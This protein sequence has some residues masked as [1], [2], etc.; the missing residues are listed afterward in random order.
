MA[1]ITDVRHQDRANG[2]VR[3]DL[4]FCRKEIPLNVVPCKYFSYPP[5]IIF[6][7]PSIIG[8]TFSSIG[9]V[10]RLDQIES[11]GDSWKST[12]KLSV[13]ID[14]VITELESILVKRGLTKIRELS[15]AGWVQ[16]RAKLDFDYVKARSDAEILVLDPPSKCDG[17]T[18]HMLIPIWEISEQ[19]GPPCIVGN[20]RFEVFATLRLNERGEVTDTTLEFKVPTLLPLTNASYK[21]T[22]YDINHDCLATY[23]PKCIE[24]FRSA[25][26]K[27]RDFLNKIAEI[28]KF[29]LEHDTIDQSF[30]SFL[31]ES[32]A[33]PKRP[34]SAVVIVQMT[35]AS[36]MASAPRITIRTFSWC[37]NMEV[38]NVPER[39]SPNWS[40]DTAAQFYTSQVRGLLGG[41]NHA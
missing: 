33:S 22:P 12:E 27:R 26:C 30:R 6:L 5:D 23:L 2:V 15:Q 37:K 11:L 14:N 13:G 8:E 35:P 20:D 4:F 1:S 40:L 28:F 31:V 10:F 24:G 3:K 38:I 7:K 18:I 19:N 41:Q 17:V 21:L 36:L 16:E 39:F 34:Q 32:R 25:W 9:N 29:T